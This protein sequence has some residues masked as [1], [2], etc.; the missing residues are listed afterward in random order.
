M[1]ESLVT[2]CPF[3][4]TRFRLSQEQLMAAAGNVRCG[5]CLRVFNASAQPPADP[6]AS[7]P[8]PNDRPSSPSGSL[9]IHD[10]MEYDELDLE[11]LGLD[12]SIVE[13]VNPPGPAAE[14]LRSDDDFGFEILD[15]QDATPTPEPEEDWPELTPA[16]QQEDE[17]FWAA[18]DAELAS[19][20]QTPHLTENLEP[21]PSPAEPNIDET[22]FTL[23]LHEDFVAS[24][25]ARDFGPRVEPAISS[26]EPEKIDEPLLA[27]PT[28]PLRPLEDEPD[29]GVFLRDRHSMRQ[30]DLPLSDALD[31]DELTRVEPGMGDLYALPD[32]HDEPIYLDDEPRRPRRKRRSGVWALLCLVAAAALVGQFVYY[33]FDA[34]ARDERTRGWLE[35]TCLLAGCNL[36]ARV[37]TE[38]LRSSNLLVRAHPEF[39]NALAID[40]MLY[41]RADFSQPFPVLR[42]RFTDSQGREVATRRF[43]PDEY[44]S[45]E[46]AG[47]ELMPP[48]TP[49]RVALSML[50]P[51]PQAVSYT[52]EFEPQ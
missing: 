2:Q 28:G 23:D 11:A 16:E 49:I 22:D 8:K 38:L 47:A 14:D 35:T 15:D 32:L 12:E 17:E 44:L 13:E 31:A 34:L 36:P 19:D 5:A 30:R 10:D 45:G 3:C 39:P 20:E 9:L 42:M 7:Q 46:L 48:Q 50:D 29:H 41:N 24:S 21:E 51:G 6:A 26:D 4:Q 25:P 18:L 43:R 33:N 37:D 52:L 27:R 1:S 40:A